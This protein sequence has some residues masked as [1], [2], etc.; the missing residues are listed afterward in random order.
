MIGAELQD[1]ALSEVRKLIKLQCILDTE[2]AWDD[3]AEPPAVTTS[4]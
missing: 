4:K 3:P 1:V 2:P